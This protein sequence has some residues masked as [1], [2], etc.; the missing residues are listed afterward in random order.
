M[1]VRWI[2]MV[3]L[4]SFLAGCGGNAATPTPATTVQAVLAAS[5]IVLGPNRLPIGLV[6]DGT[7]INEPQAKVN[8]RFYYLDGDP[9]QKNKVVGESEATYFGQNLPIGVYVAYPVFPKAGA[10]AVDVEATLPGQPTAVSRLRLDVQQS[11]PTPPLGSQAVAVDT[12]TV[13]TTD[14]LTKITSDPEP[15]PA[16]YQISLA[17]ALQQNKPVAVLFGTPGFCKT[18]TCGPSVKVLGQLQER[19]GDRM[20]FIHVEVYQYP[21]GESFKANP[22]HFSEGMQAW[23][24]QTEPWLFLI[25]SQGVIRAKY[26]GGITIDEMA[27]VVEDLLAQS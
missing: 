26:E 3:V 13:A 16:L 12:P 5:T 11:D 17:D 24:L 7:P 10:W 23:G 8:L 20:N 9:A 19:Y 22:P 15:N 6:V 14:D 4:V 18:A 21:F 27:P 25:D 2:G 1:R